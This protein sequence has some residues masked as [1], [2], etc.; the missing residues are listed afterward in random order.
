MLDFV[1]LYFLLV[2]Y[3]NEMTKLIGQPPGFTPLLFSAYDAKL[4]GRYTGTLNHGM[5]PLNRLV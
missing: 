4:E 3:F 2:I 5:A 1:I